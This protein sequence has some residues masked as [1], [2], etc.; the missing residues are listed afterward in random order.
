MDRGMRYAGIPGVEKPVSRILFGAGGGRFWQGERMDELLDAVFAL[1]VT[2]FDTARVYGD[3]EKVLGDWLERRNLREKVVLLSKCAHP[4]LTDGTKRVNEREIRREFEISSRCL[5]TDYIDIYLLHR[6]DPQVEAGLLVELL[7]AM[8]AEGKIG[9]FGGSNWT[10]RRIEEANE[11]AYRRNLIPFTVSSPNYG[12]ARQEKTKIGD[13]V[14]LSGLEDAEEK[15]WYAESQMPLLAYSALGAGFF[16]GRFQ[17]GD[18]EAALENADAF[19]RSVYG[20]PDNFER[21]RR[22]EELA[23]EKGCKVSTLALAWIFAGPLNTFAVVSTGSP[24]RMEENIEALHLPLAE[25]ERRYLN[26][27]ERE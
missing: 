11:Y 13:C 17:S 3:S 12:L 14:T 20:S 15:A 1:G 8:H 23:K 2:A 21:L 4:D 5:K 27:E 25:A 9:A 18:G 10:R 24:K 19:F 26:L 6:D 7:N 22:C 16:S